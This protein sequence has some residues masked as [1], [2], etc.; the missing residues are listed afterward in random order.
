MATEYEQ[1]TGE[2][3]TFGK[4]ELFRAA[5]QVLSWLVGLAVAAF[6]GYNANVNTQRMDAGTVNA[7]IAVQETKTQNIEYRIDGMD[8]KLDRLLELMIEQIKQSSSDSRVR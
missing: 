8:H 1:R 7:R 4:L 2:R 6:I 5:W 3:R